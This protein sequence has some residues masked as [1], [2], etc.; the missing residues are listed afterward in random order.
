MP[1]A[2]IGLIAGAGTFPLEIARAV[3]ASGHRT[4]V[5]ALNELAD[6]ELDTVG[7]EVHWLALGQFE[8]LFSVWRAADVT[9]VVMAG[10]VPKTFLWERP[11][12]VQLD[13]VAKGLIA[14]LADRADDSLMGAVAHAIES[15][16][17][18]LLDQV[19]LT[20]E[21]AAPVGVLGAH[22]PSDA[23]WADIAFGWPVAKALGG[24]DVGQSIVVQDRA[25]LA[26]EA[27]EG[28]DAAI[29][30]G[31]ALASTDAQTPPCVVKVAKPS[32]DPRF[33]M[34]TVGL[35]TVRTMA[36]GGAGVLAME[37]GVTVV[38]NR[39]ALVREADALGIVVVGVDEASLRGR[40]EP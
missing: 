32:Q 38:V 27:V 21:L 37:A 18:R 2:P 20:P 19:S 11:E 33:D 14:Q 6:R 15:N 12:A 9:E 40:A 28:T 26:L 7:D 5:C 35:D 30:R 34:P 3:R 4:V 29:T 25:V 39:A 31:C 17:F 24:M 13:A 16:G 23:M 10:K 1:D 22:V 8:A 36:A